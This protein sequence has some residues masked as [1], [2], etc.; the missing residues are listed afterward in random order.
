MSPEY[1]G[2]RE[3]E[4]AHSS[5]KGLESEKKIF[6]WG[7]VSTGDYIKG[8]DLNSAFHFTLAASEFQD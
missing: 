5:W 4:E 1:L 8:Y 7:K 3:R 6:F 2:T